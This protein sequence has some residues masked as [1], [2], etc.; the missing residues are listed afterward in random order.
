MVVS[1]LKPHISSPLNGIPNKL[2]LNIYHIDDLNHSH[3]DPLSPNHIA[4]N[5]PDPNI[6]ALLN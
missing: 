3:V 1:L 2:K 6:D 4:E 5:L